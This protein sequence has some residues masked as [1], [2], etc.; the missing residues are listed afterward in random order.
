M[1]SYAV[2]LPAKSKSGDAG[3]L[4]M[5][6]RNRE[7]EKAWKCSAPAKKEKKSYGEPATV[8]GSVR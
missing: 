3:N 2:P 5:P 6:E 7:V 8:Y 4:E 1:R